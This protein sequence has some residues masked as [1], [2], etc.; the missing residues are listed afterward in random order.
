MRLLFTAMLVV[1]FGHV[2]GIAFASEGGAAGEPRH[3]KQLDW[4]FEGILGTFDRQSAQRGFKVYKEVC[5]ACHSIKRIAFRNL[6]ELG[7]SEAE[8]KS[9]AGS[10][11]IKDGPNDEGEMFERPGRPSDRIPSPFLNDN[12]ARAAN[13]GALPPDLSLII[14]AREDGPNYVYSLLTGYETPPEGFVV[15]ENMHYNPYF[16]A[17]GDQLAMPPP[18]IED[19]QIEYTDGTSSTIDQMSKDVVNF[20]EWTAEPELEE[21]KAMGLRVLIFLSVFTGIFYLAYK[22]IWRNV[23]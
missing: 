1:L 18:L 23:H 8:V 9:L 4:K 11:L 21:R 2:G 14:K 6:Q 20:L 13:N 12:A 22:K 16:A 3:P 17:G 10:Y 5:S 19:G 15:G 7:F